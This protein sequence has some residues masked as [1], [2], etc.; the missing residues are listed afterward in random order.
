MGGMRTDIGREITPNTPVFICIVSVSV[1]HCLAVFCRVEEYPQLTNY[2]TEQVKKVSCSNDEIKDK[3]CLEIKVT[4]EQ[5]EQLYNEIKEEYLINYSGENTVIQTENVVFQVSTLSEQNENNPNVSSI[6]LGDC[7]NTIKRNKGIPDSMSLVVFKTDTKT[8][9][10]TQTYVQYEVY[11][12]RDLL[13][14]LDI[15]ICDSVSISVPIKLDSATSE[16]YDSLKESGYDLFDENDPFYNDICSIYTSE[17]GTD[18]TLNDRRT[19]I[20]GS[21]G[22]ITLCQSGC[23]LEYYNSTSKKAKCQCSP[24]TKETNTVLSFSNEQFDVKKI[25]ESF[26]TTLQ[27]SNFLVLKC[28]QLVIDFSNFFSNIG[29][30]FMS[31]IVLLSTISLVIFCV[32]DNKKIDNF[33]QLILKDKLS[34]LKNKNN[35]NVIQSNP[36]NITQNI[37][38]KKV[39]KDKKSKKEEKKEKKKPSSF[40][41]KKNGKKKKNNPPKKKIVTFDLKKRNN[42]NYKTKVNSK[43]T[44][45]KTNANALSNSTNI[46]IVKIN[47]YNLSKFKNNNTENNKEKIRNKKTKLKTS[48]TNKNKRKVCFEPKGN[49]SNYYVTSNILLDLK[50]KSKEVNAQAIKNSNLYKNLNDQEINSLEYEIAIIID[51]RTYIS[52]LLV[53]IKTE[54]INIIYFLPNTRL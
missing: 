25:A 9:D 8:K 33:I 14:P 11:D 16:L 3:K 47:N 18:M 48:P 13:T 10:L 23:E 36:K 7:E 38:S 43:E 34:N 28:Y 54:T 22:N 5:M 51:Q 35:T 12:P 4:E 26:M 31:V 21:S 24:Q 17:N 40:K 46:N 20:F 42:T 49:A 30:V 53:F 45:K 29:R 37:T 41:P 27:N 2:I 1:N 15:S 52:I 32:Y 50:N 44:L 39:K 6:N 19:Q